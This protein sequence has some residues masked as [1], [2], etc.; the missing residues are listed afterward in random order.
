MSD[1]FHDRPLPCSFSLSELVEAAQGDRVGLYRLPQVSPHEYLAFQWVAEK[2]DQ[3]QGR[4]R[5]VVFLR[6]YRLSTVLLV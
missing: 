3:E 2:T 6:K 4:I 1:S 5:T